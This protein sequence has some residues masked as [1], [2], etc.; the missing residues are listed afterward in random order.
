MPHTK[1]NPRPVAMHDRIRR[2]VDADDRSQVEIAKAAG[3]SRAQ[4]N[5]LLS[6]VRPNPTVDTVERL[7]AAMGRRWA[8]LD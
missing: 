3:M 7:L 6:G 1:I 2:L 5:H 8:D 4:L